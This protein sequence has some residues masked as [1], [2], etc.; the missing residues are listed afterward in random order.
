MGNIVLEIISFC[1]GLLLI[2]SIFLWAVDNPKKA[3]DAGLG[4]GDKFIKVSTGA[5]KFA[6]KVGTRIVT[7]SNSSMNETIAQKMTTEE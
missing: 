2:L 6:V 3:I 1:I 4:I 7:Y 5:V